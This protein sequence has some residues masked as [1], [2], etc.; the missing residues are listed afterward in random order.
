MSVTNNVRRII[1]I[2][3]AHNSIVRGYRNTTRKQMYNF[4][5]THDVGEEGGNATEVFDLIRAI[6]V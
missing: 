2:S 4:L 6:K 5:L 1:V 3:N